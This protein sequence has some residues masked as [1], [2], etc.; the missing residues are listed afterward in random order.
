VTEL[1]YGL[2]KA[3]ENGLKLAIFNSCDGLGLARQLDDLQIPQIIVMRELIPD[4]VA[5]EFL[6]Y[7]LDELSKNRPFYLAVKAARERL[8]G[9]ESKFPCA[10]WLPVIY[11]NPSEEPFA[12]IQDPIKLPKSKFFRN[13]IAAASVLIALGVGGWQ[14]AAPKIAIWINNSGLQK[15]LTG[16]P[17]NWLD[18]ETALKLNPNNPAI[19][20]NQA[21]QCEDLKDFE[22]AKTKYM[23]A[24]KMGFAPA[25]SNLARLYIKQYQDYDNAADILKQ[26]LKYNHDDPKEVKYALIKNLGWA[27]LGQE[28]Y[29]D[30]KQHLLEAIEIQ[31]DRAPAYCLLA[32][33]LDA[34]NKPI[35]ALEKWEKCLS[36]ASK[37]QPDEDRWID[38]ARQRLQEAK[39][40]KTWQ[41]NLNGFPP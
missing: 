31:G 13:K 27:R 9:L 25:Y 33:V 34:Q 18:F 10:S 19:L 20:Y 1:W 41:A 6:K 8:Q 30:A 36:F 16:S 14:L 11:Q 24:A 29:E 3:V 5:Q 28:R 23:Q 17:Q 22:C 15:Y 4:I 2:R 12:W 37:E 21:Y 39:G 35:T 32:E 38:M 7:F 26:G 40:N